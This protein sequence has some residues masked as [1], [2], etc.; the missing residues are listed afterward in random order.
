VWAIGGGASAG[1]PGS[2][3]RVVVFYLGVFAPS[4]VAVWL[5]ARR[6]GRAGVRALLR[7]LVQWDVGLRWYVFALTY[8]VAIKLAAGLFPHSDAQIGTGARLPAAYFRAVGV[9]VRAELPA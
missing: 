8:I 7:R 5:T 2:G 3:L 6:E 9:V 4:F 1:Y